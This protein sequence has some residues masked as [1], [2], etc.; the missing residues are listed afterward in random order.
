[1]LK[2]WNRRVYI[3]FLVD[4][5]IQILKRCMEEDLFGYDFMG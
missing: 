2:V 4:F 1:M 3:S 5:K